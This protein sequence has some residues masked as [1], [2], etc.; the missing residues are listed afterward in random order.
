M[1]SVRISASRE[2]FARMEAAAILA[3]FASPLIIECCGIAISFKR[4]VDQEM[5]RD[6]AQAFNSPPHCEN[7]RP[8]D[9]DG[10]DFLDIDKR[11]RP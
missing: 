7:A 6:N 3:D 1:S 8:V 10:V 4:F 9:V 2:T 5:L 11:D